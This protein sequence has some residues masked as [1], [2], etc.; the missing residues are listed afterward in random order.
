MFLLSQ[1]LSQRIWDVENSLL[2][3]V[4][5]T[6]IHFEYDQCYTVSCFFQNSFKNTRVVPIFSALFSTSFFFSSA[7]SYE[8]MTSNA[9]KKKRTGFIILKDV[10][11][12]VYQVKQLSRIDWL[13]QQNFQ[14]LYTF[15]N[16]W[17]PLV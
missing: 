16:Q 11:R 8:V 2:I 4:T 1:R 13:L 7:S 6:I 10:L 9:A 3:A 12:H 5:L 14:S 17:S 15:L